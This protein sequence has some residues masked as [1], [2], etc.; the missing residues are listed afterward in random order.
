MVVIHGLSIAEVLTIHNFYLKYLTITPLAGVI[1]LPWEGTLWAAAG[2]K[3]LSGTPLSCRRAHS[4]GGG[5]PL[6]TKGG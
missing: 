6:S 1:T 3:G 5:S 4:V 2:M